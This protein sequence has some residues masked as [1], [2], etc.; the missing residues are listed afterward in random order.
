M[1]NGSLGTKIGYNQGW[2]VKMSEYKKDS[3]RY[4]KCQNSNFERIIMSFKNFQ[5]FC[6]KIYLG[7]ITVKFS[8]N[9]LDSNFIPVISKSLNYQKSTKLSDVS[10]LSNSLFEL[11]EILEKSLNPTSVQSKGMKLTCWTNLLILSSFISFERGRLV[12]GSSRELSHSDQ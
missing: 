8:N 10:R 9:W 3:R 5:H 2:R 7:R 1:V 4:R 11:F 6:E 12:K